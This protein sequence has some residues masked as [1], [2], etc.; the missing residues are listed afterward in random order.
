[1]KSTILRAMTR[2]G[3]ARLLVINS[4]EMINNTQL[5][6]NY[7]LFIAVDEEGGSVSRLADAGISYLAEAGLDPTTDLVLVVLSK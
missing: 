2:D 4:K 6:S 1:M 5:Y 3:S 7:P